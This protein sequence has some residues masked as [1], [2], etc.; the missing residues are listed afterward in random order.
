MTERWKT[1]EHFELADLEAVRIL[2]RGDS[3]IDWHRLN[4]EGTEEIR[5]FVRA[6]EL[7]PDNPE[8]RERMDVV[9]Q[10]A[11][12]YL[13]RHFDYPIPK[14]VA[15]ATTEELVAMACKS[16][17]HRQVCACSILKCMHIIHHLDGREL[18]FMLPLSDQEV[19]Q[20]V[21]EKVYRV[22][23]GMLASGFP[24]SEFVGGR[25]HRDSL[26][27]KLLSK[28]DTIA[29]QVY[30]KLR[31]RI[32]TK[33]ERDI[34][35]VLEYLTRKLVPFNYV[36]PGQSIN[37]IF[38]FANYC[39]AHPRLKPML[40][41][42]QAGKDEEFTPSDNVFSAQNY[43]VVHFVVDMPVRLPER[44]L[45]LAPPE[46]ARFGRIVFVVCEFQIIDEA[47]EAQN[48]IG[49]ASHAKYKERQ[50]KA[51]MRRLQ[52]GMREMKVPPRSSSEAPDSKREGPKSEI[53]RR[54]S[55]SSLPAA[56]KDRK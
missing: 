40:K 2:L 41:E 37:S 1:L 43:R 7:S 19:F 15:Q 48:E 38:Q 33:S 51:V 47:T 31:F 20:L 36:I 25:K 13:K 55:S 56:K 14:P 18:L 34:F 52:L 45:E 23:G 44:V 24:I 54:A 16:G 46:A 5:D 10:E 32:V 8:D 53:A 35:P 6:H 42:M 28:E 50:K 27:T 9:K 30:D 17:G 4:F 26:Y 11:I 29:A 21:E 49:D 12:A 22:I 39:R 3:V